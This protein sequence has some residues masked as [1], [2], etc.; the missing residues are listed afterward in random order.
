MKALEEWIPKLYSLSSGASQ[1]ELKKDEQF[2][3]KVVEPEFR[4]I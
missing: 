3:F 4:T 2:V 1:Y